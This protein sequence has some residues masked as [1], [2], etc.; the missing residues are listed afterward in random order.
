MGSQET[1]T[2]VRC[3]CEE[4]WALTMSYAAGCDPLPFFLHSWRNRPKRSD[5]W[6]LSRLQE[7][8]RP[9]G[10]RSFG[11]RMQQS[12]DKDREPVAANSVPAAI[13]KTFE[14]A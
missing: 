7:E 8:S 10:E 4:M 11:F 9:P 1:E 2:Y 5:H 6:T 3:M 13:E 12:P 14:Q